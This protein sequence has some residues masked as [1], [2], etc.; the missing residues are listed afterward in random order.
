MSKRKKYEQ[1][2]LLVW[3][4]DFC[5][6]PRLGPEDIDIFGQMFWCRDVL[7]EQACWPGNIR[8]R[9][10][11]FERISDF[12]HAKWHEWDGDDVERTLHVIRLLQRLELDLNSNKVPD[13]LIYGELK[14]SKVIH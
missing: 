5:R 2:G 6:L 13:W 10:L 14:T 8:P 11:A 1:L 12:V 3:Q 9:E 4:D 7:V